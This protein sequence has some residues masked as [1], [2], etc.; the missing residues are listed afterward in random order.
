[1]K[2]N[3]PHLTKMK[4]L[5]FIAFCEELSRFGGILSNMSADISE[6]V[7]GAGIRIGVDPAGR[8][9]FESSRS[10]PI[11]NSGAFSKYNMNMIGKVTPFALAYDKAFDILKADKRIHGTL[12][13]EQ[14]LRRA[15]TLKVHG[16]MLINELGKKNRGWI[17]F[18]ATDYDPKKLGNIV[19]FVF[20]ATT[21][22]GE[23]LRVCGNASEVRKNINNYDPLVCYLKKLSTPA[24]KFEGVDIEK[25]EVNLKGL[26][27][28]LFKHMTKFDHKKLLV[29]RKEKDKAEKK[30]LLSLIRMIQVSMNTKILESMPEGK[31][32]D[33]EG[34]VVQMENSSFKVINSK[35]TNEKTKEDEKWA[36]TSR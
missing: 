29:S 36:E 5:D 16:E 6:K 15:A 30:R 13:K 14:D 28:Y 3:I 24:V 27:L 2:I 22:N 1:M 19:T 35:F 26:L 32:G 31:F 4:P 9:F 21:K 8:F 34:I 25:F 33:M 20:F 23:R 11:Y 17:R 10:G 12:L 7:D 18:I